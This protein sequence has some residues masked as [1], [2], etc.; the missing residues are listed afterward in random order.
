[1]IHQNFYFRVK[2]RIIIFLI[3]QHTLSQAVTLLIHFIHSNFN[4]MLIQVIA[5]SSKQ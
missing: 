2:L 5:C 4:Y 3:F 1:M